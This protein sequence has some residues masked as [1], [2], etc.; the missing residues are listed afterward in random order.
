MKKKKQEFNEIDRFMQKAR[1]QGLTY[2]QLQVKETC[3]MMK[4]K[5]LAERKRDEQSL[6]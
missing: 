1:A 4:R 5:E 3:E 2:A 6:F